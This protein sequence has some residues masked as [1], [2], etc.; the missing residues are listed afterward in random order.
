MNAINNC[1]FFRGGVVGGIKIVAYCFGFYEGF[2]RRALFII[3]T[4]M[5]ERVNISRVIQGQNRFRSTVLG[6]N[7]GAFLRA[8]KVQ[9]IHKK[10][11]Y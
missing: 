1:G 7:I 3:D 11:S 10:Y 8:K 4:E 9:V 5:S 6:M 2:R